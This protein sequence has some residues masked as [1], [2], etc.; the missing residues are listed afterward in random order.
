MGIE[1]KKEV[2]NQN[3]KDLMSLVKGDA[4]KTSAQSAKSLIKGV[5]KKN[6]I[7]CPYCGKDIDVSLLK[8]E[9]DD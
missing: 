6:S 7:P 8:E 2:K 1:E 9:S 5:E 4:L 3:I